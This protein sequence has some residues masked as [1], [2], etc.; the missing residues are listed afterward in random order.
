[1]KHRLAFWAIAGF[2]VAFFWV[3][4]SLAIPLS[5]Q[6]VLW[7]FAQLTCPVALFA[8]FAVKWYGVV[9][10]NGLV[11]LMLGVVCEGLLRLAGSHPASA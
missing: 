4:L 11:Y 8:R 7:R 5:S 10:S 3:L 1:M 6:P 2:L 9:L